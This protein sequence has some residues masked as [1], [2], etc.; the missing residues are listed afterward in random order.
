MAVTALEIT[1][2][3]PFAFGYERLDGIIRFAVDPLDPANTPIVDL[4]KAPRD[5]Q[6]RVHFW[7]DFL[8]LRPADAAHANRRL[9][10][11]VVNRGRR[12]NVPMCRGA[13]GAQVEP[14]TD[15][16]DPGDGFLLERGWTIAMCGWQ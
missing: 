6:G 15:D 12:T 7:D 4:D 13:A 8:L 3:Q 9:L 5:G 2:R 16:I 11:H 14:P 10:Y 1:R